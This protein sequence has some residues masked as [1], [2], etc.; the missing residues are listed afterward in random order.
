MLH[1]FSTIK[2]IYNLKDMVL[3]TIKIYCNILK[4]DLEGIK[5]VLCPLPSDMTKIISLF[6]LLSAICD[7]FFAVSSSIMYVEIV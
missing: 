5:G 7:G 3:L 2:D 1:V 6:P 4:N